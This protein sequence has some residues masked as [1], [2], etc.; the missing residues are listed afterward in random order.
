[1]SELSRGALTTVLRRGVESFERNDEREFLPAALEV[2]ETP[3]SPAGRLLAILIGAFFTIAVAWAFLGKVDVIATAPGRVLPSGKTKVIQPLDPGTVKT[4]AVQDG[5]HVKAGQLL[6]ALDPTTTSADRDRLT[7]DLVQTRLDV[8]RLS[9]L[10]PVA[11]GRGGP[12]QIGAVEGATPDDLAQARAALRAQLDAQAAKVAGLDQQTSEKRAEAA[13]VTA[14]IAKTNASLPMLTEKARLHEKLRQQGF[15]TSFANLDAQQQLSDAHRDLEVQAKRLDQS[16]AYAAAL[17]RQRAQAASEFDAGVLSDLQKA[18]EKENQLS[19][20]LIKAQQKSTQ[21]EIRSPIDGVVEEL[22]LHTVGGVVTPAERLMIVV[23]DTRKLMV[24]AQLANRDVGFVHTGQDVSVKIETFNFTRYGLVHG[25]VI[26]VSR[27]AVA[28]ATRQADE[29][30]GASAQQ[31]QQPASP[32]SPTY[33]ARVSLDR[34][35]MVV[36]GRREPLIPGMSV[37]AEVKTGRR[38]IINYLLSPL[39]R[40]SNEA[41]HE[42]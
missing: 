20:D 9:A 30:S 39:A 8:A 40:K 18:R 12:G 4:I 3:P 26:D 36:D 14:L 19:Q 38:T 42:R 25:K 32:A 1:M 2:L 37:T 31:Q 6:I 33:M 7:H 34:T 28:A 23:P 35:S 41:L 22:A 15:G 16:R 27:D 13:E 5:D 10:A 24:E 21:T 29:S 17:Q 11:E